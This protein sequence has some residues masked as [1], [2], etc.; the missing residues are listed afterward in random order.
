MKVAA[1]LNVHSNPEVVL[2]TLDSIQTYLTKDILVV[3]DGAS[4]AFDHTPL[5]VS[6]IKGF[7]HNARKAPYRN[8]ALGL[9]TLHDMYPAADWFCYSEYDCLFTSSLILQNL[10]YASDN[11]VWMLGNDGH[12]DEIEIPIIESIVKQKF[13]GSYY[14]L[15]ACQFFNKVFMDRLV[16]MNFFE[17]LLM[18][19]NAYTDGFFPLFYG[20]DISE[21]MYPTIARYLGGKIGV[22]ATYDYVQK[23]WHGMHEF[24]PVRWAPDLDPDTENFPQMSIAHPIK[25]FRSP[26]RVHHREK[27][28]NAIQTL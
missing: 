14:L 15:G 10:E 5:P 3:I 4:T 7:P 12:V 2:D 23:Q 1:I 25:D 13:N 22:F 6:S 24:F 20:H 19:T 17:K 16:E 9:I 21:H 8:V 18:A 11:D 27:R 26:I 28:K